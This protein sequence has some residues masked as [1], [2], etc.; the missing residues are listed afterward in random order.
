MQIDWTA[1]TLAVIALFAISGFFKGW[2]KE[3]VTTAFFAFLLFLLQSPE[4]AQ[5]FIDF[6]NTII[7]FI[8]RIT[9][10]FIKPMMES[11]L[12]VSSGEV[13]ALDAS[14]PSTWIIILVFSMVVAIIFG[15]FSLRS[16]GRRTRYEPGPLGSLL[17]GLLGGLNGFI[18][19]GLIREYLSGRN[20]PGSEA[21]A[22][23]G[24]AA[25]ADGVSTVATATSEVTIQA[26]NL[27]NFTITDSFL[28]WVLMLFGAGVLIMALTNRTGVSNKDGFR[29]V[30]TKTPFG[31]KKL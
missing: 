23:S 29:K 24:G 7:S 27:P 28:P 20:L 12:G 19:M 8:W 22:L 3:A 5:L 31:Y 26:V 4:A 21:V 2:W 30:H 11:V 16:D 17:G 10:S 25:A 9:P 14:D 1:L 15:R 18:F 13:P 6:I